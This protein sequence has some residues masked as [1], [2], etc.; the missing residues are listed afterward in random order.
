MTREDFIE[1]YIRSQGLTFLHQ[2]I[3]GEVFTS[4]DVKVTKE[5]IGSIF[6]LQ[7]QIA[8]KDEVIDYLDKR[9]INLEQEVYKK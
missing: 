8:Q 2:I 4:P 3:D 9:L 6:D 1:N 5:I 7:Q